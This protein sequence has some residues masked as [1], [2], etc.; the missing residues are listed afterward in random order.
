MPKTPAQP[1]IVLI[2]GHDLGDWLSCYDR[3]DIPSPNLQ[4]FADDAVIFDA[5]FATSP[6]CT[7]AR[8]SLFTGQMPHA[9]GLMG[10]SHAGWRYAPGV[11]TLPE[12]LAAAGYRTALLGLQHEDL[13]ARVLGYEEVHGQGFLPRALEVARLSERW[14]ADA[15]DD[16]RPYF[17][18]V[19]MWEVHRPWPLEDYDPV[20]PQS[21]QL[22][23]YMPDNDHTRT[24]VSQFLGAIRQ[25]D[26]AVG[27]ILAAIE[28][29]PGAENTMVIFTTDHGVAFPR[30]KSTL[31]DS[32]VKVALLIKA[33]STW[34][35][36]GGRSDLLV[37]HLDIVPTLVE[38]AG[39][40]LPEQID[41]QSLLGAVSG[42]QLSWSDRALV[43]EKTYHDRY[44]PI[45]AIRT[46]TAKYIR[47]YVEAVQL[48]LSLDLEQSETRRGMGDAHLQPRPKEELYRLDVDPWEL[49]NLAADS[50][51]QELRA[52]LSDALDARL[53]QSN[54]P[55]L[56]GPIPAP[57]QPHRGD[58]DLSPAR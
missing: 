45:R 48:P 11:Q 14:F 42:E 34:G 53:R 41:G 57:A 16:E 9:N 37:S 24:D 50:A 32:G 54:D 30:A 2:H 35:V 3:S 22:P 13:D 40:P 4:R 51:H 23:P 18:A 58:V 8:S 49:S 31:Y 46:K 1:N 12:M 21:V 56:S 27:R 38:V 52:E 36:A 39:A 5:A 55:I 25:M 26:E 28:A 29:S 7:P 10:L 33:P 43:L 44:D 17:A 19:G 20:D 6:L 15:G 47:N